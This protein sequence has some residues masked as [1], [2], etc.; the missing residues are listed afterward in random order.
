[1]NDLGTTDEIDTNE[2]ERD[3]MIFWSVIMFHFDPSFNIKLK[4]CEKG[5]RYLYYITSEHTF[6]RVHCHKLQ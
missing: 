3:E 5:D 1:M 6:V 4:V 2:D